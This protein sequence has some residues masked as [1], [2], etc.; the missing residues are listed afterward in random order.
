[1]YSNSNYVK[2]E[3]NDSELVKPRQG[4]S[5]MHQYQNM[6]TNSGYVKRKRDEKTC[7]HCGQ[8]FQTREN[9]RNHAK[10]CKHNARYH[11]DK[12]LQGGVVW[13]IE[14]EEECRKEEDRA[15]DRGSQNNGGESEEKHAKYDWQNY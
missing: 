10:V 7:A 11:R 3:F 8:K 15:K 9:Q 13:T 1:M 4:D 5:P 6:R 2:N 14:D 12:K